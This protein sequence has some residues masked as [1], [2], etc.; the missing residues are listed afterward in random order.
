MATAADPSEQHLPSD[1]IFIFTDLETESIQANILLQI[2]A[3][4]QKGETFNIFINPQ[5]PLTETCTNLLG[6]FYFNGEL[7]REGQRLPSEHIKTALHNFTHWIAQ[8]GKPVVLVFHNGFSFDCTVL[9]R[10]LIQHQVPIPENLIF[11]AD[12]LPYIRIA[13]KA[14]EIDNH[15]LG[16][17]AKYFNI[18][19]ELAHDALS[20]SLTLMHICT[21]I[22]DR[23]GVTY[24]TIFKDSYRHFSDYLNRIMKGTPIRPLK[25]RSKRK[26]K[27][28][29]ETET[30]I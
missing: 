30:K 14:P 22:A 25:K 4:T 20:D 5:C 3:V 8:F 2:A 17:L 9:A 21:K 11:V 26:T 16:T 27:S 1:A 28:K 23:N 7:Y 19:H 6:L 24:Q 13:L 18:T 10:F 15:K 29:K 12:S